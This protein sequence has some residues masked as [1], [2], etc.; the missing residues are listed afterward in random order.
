[1]YYRFRDTYQSLQVF[2]ILY[3]PLTGPEVRVSPL[4]SLLETSS[5]LPATMM[6]LIYLSGFTG[7]Q[8]GIFCSYYLGWEHSDDGEALFL[9]GHL[10][11][12]TNVNTPHFLFDLSFPDKNS[13]KRN[14]RVHLPLTLPPV[15]GGIF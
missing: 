10:F 8:R 13:E 7:Y 15:C 3:L 14:C 5:P 6:S 1:M 2:L 4:F 9:S 12:L 11:T